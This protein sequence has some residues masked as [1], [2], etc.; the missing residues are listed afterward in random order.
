MSPSEIQDKIRNALEGAE[1]CAQEA[2]SYKTWPS[3]WFR[4]DRSHV[5]LELRERWLDQA[6]TYRKM[7]NPLN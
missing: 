3:R 2:A 6:D 1:R 5:W 4:E 7:L